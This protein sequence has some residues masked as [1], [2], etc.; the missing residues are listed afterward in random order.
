MDTKKVSYV[1]AGNSFRFSTSYQN[2]R[3]KNAFV[4]YKEDLN[5]NIIKKVEYLNHITFVPYKDLA[6]AQKK[7][8][9]YTGHSSVLIS[10][11]K[12]VP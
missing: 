7:F 3:V 10:N 8:N 6:D 12:E 5:K 2:S 4:F 1:D 11:G 9:T